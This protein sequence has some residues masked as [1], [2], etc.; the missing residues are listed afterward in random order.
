M[1]TKGLTKLERKRVDK[2]HEAVQDALMEL[3]DGVNEFN[4]AIE[5]LFEDWICA[6]YGEYQ[7]AAEEYTEVTR[8]LAEAAESL[9]SD[10]SDKWQEGERGEAFREFA[11]ELTVASEYELVD[12][13]YHAPEPV[14]SFDEEVPEVPPN[15]A[16]FEV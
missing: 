8:E 16:F 4:G 14:D 7:A 9:Y 2:L 13:D 6:R 11:D 5:Q 3:N 1:N 10:K 15:D 12:I